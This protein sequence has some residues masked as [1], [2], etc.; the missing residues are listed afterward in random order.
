MTSMDDKDHQEQKKLNMACPKICILRL[1]RKLL[2]AY[3]RFRINAIALTFRICDREI[4][5][6][7]AAFDF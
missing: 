2:L 1:S 6:M 7:G 3:C 5:E 4:H